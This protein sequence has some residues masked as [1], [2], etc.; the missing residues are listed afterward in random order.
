MKAPEDVNEFIEL[1]RFLISLGI[2]CVVYVMEE[3]W[4]NDWATLKKTKMR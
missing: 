2:N 4:K 3:G 1:K